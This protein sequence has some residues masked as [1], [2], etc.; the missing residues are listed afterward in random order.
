MVHQI[1]TNLEFLKIPCKEVS[2]KEGLAI[3]E[4]LKQTLKTSENG[5]G[6]AA[7]QCGIN[8]RVCVVNV[9][10]PLILVNPKITDQDGEIISFESC[11]SFP[12]QSVRTKRAQYVQVE[13]DN[14]GKTVFG[15]TNGPYWDGKQQILE[16]VC[17]QHEIAHLNGQTMFDFEHKLLPVTQKQTLSRNDK[18]TITNGIET[19]VLKWKK[20]QQ[21]VDSGGWKIYTN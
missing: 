17:I 13:D 3:G 11:L 15:P 8:A 4:S 9:I 19:K 12:N 10:S 2:L 14:L 7:N 21:L 1:I 18:V 16:S 5:I 20:A 6:L